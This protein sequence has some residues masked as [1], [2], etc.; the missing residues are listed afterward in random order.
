MQA[1]LSPAARAGSAAASRAVAL[2]ISPPTTAKDASRAAGGPPA[3]PVAVAG[4]I[5]EAARVTG[6]VGFALM[7]LA[8][9]ELLETRDGEGAYPPASV[10]KLF[11][12]AYALETLGP[13]FRF[14]TRVQAAG[15]PANGR[16]AGDLA[17][18]GGGDPEL[19][20]DAL[21]E[22]AAQLRARGVSTVTGRFLADLS[23]WPDIPYID[24]EQPEDASYNPSVGGLNLDFNR[25]LFSWKRAGS[26]Y[27]L[28]MEARGLRAATPARRVAIGLGST[29]AG[30][31]A[32]V[33]EPG[34]EVWTVLAGALGKDGQR[35]LPVRRP[36]LHAA[37]VFRS[38][39][40]A[41]GVTLPAAEMGRAPAGGATLALRRSRTLDAIVQDMLK[42]STNLT[43]E[44]VGL[45]ATALREAP[46]GDLERRGAAM[47]RWAR[48]RAATGAGLAGAGIAGAGTETSPATVRVAS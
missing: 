41:D 23:G 18:V 2:N 22:L 5:A 3:N 44:A 37:E 10:A 15:A 33:D 42:Y 25:V 4:P 36:A 35:W 9:G 19:D 47:S 11:T 45:G 6:R 13:D 39:A 1:S 27:D 21:A 28:A 24:P 46:A 12:A 29:G 43:A 48:A 14:E 32:R 30:T 20:T 16:L 38:F 7:D 40:A 34:R 17:L 8:T 26:G 31:F